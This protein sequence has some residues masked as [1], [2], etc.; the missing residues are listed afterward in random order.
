MT[1]WN[2]NPAEYEESSFSIIPV[3]DHRV[4][5]NEVT[6]K[7]F[8]GGRQ[9]YEIILDVSGQSGKLW[10]YLVLNPDDTKRTNQSIGSF[11]DS[12]GITDYDMSHYN[13][14]KGKIGA[15]RVKHEKYNGNDTAKVA[16]CIGKK[17]QDKLPAWKENG[18]A[19]SDPGVSVAPVIDIDDLPFR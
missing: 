2:F 13:G 4:R 14:W 3:G 8:N 16:F 7:T 17:N 11:F 6:F 9:G 19:A 5:V 18:T 1:N 15:V 10:F 12:F